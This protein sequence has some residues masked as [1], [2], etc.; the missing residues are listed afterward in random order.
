M[1]EDDAPQQ[2]IVSEDP[3][4]SMRRV[5]SIVAIVGLTFSVLFI[6]SMLIIFQV[7]S[8]R[9]TD[10][11]ITRF[12]GG[13]L[14]ALPTAVGLYLLPFS[15]IAFIWFIVALRMWASGAVRRRTVLQS[16]LQLVSGIAFVILTFVAAAASTVV[17][18][19]VQLEG[20]PPEATLARQFSLFGRAVTL[21]FAVK[22]AAM[23]VFTTSLIG[24]GPN[25]L[26]DWFVYAGFVVGLFL[27]V[28]P[29][30]SPALVLAFPIW[31]VVLCAII[32]RAARRL[33]P[34]LRVGDALERRG[35]D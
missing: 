17:A 23:Y 30:F 31:V 19:T 24:R 29:F 18:G 14:A 5:A 33:P 28:S 21:F 15:G 13:G 27:L 12:Y 26:P 8:P 32:F 20:N 34:G 22:M 1:T 3:G 16:D 6:A 9:S 35:S 11:E 25:F 7:P 10:E 4:W 2:V